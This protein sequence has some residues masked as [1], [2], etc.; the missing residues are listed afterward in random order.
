MESLTEI[1][2]KELL[3]WELLTTILDNHPDK[4]LH[5]PGSIPW[6]SR[7]IYAHLARWFTHSNQLMKKYLDTGSTTPPL[8]RVTI[9]EMNTRWQQEDSTMTLQDAR[10]K[11]HDMFEERLGIL[12]S[13][14]VEQ[15]DSQLY[16]I[17]M[18]DGYLHFA[19]HRSYIRL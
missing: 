7:D 15:W 14:P 1:I 3:E 13:I 16:E 10:K 2:P 4:N 12:R 9:E 19:I 5:S 17:A 6:T 8:N 18:Q 11:A